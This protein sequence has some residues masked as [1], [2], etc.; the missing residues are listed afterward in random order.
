MKIALAFVGLV[1]VF[2][3]VI[4]GAFD[5][6][7]GTEFCRLSPSDWC[8]EAGFERAVESSEGVREAW[9]RLVATVRG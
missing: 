9:R 7:L 4:H 8:R 1:V 2:P 6:L 5:A 3:V